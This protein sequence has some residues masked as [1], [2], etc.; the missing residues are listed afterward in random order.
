MKALVQRV[1]G[2][3]EISVNGKDFGGFRGPGLVA[4]LCWERGDEL[5][6][7]LAQ[8]EAWIQSRILGLRV[9]PDPQGRLNLGLLD[10]PT[11]EQRGI[12]WVSQFSLVAQLES[13]FRPSFAQAME[14]NAARLRWE[15]F[16]ECVK[17]ENPP[18]IVCLT[19]EFGADMS[20][21]FTNWGP[22]TIPLQK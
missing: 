6:A 16:S 20:L 18:G 5:R 14:P 13:G 11:Q 9:F 19:G 17:K 15:S 3:C 4:L 12:L 8:A 21:Q 22:L 7:D 10:Y 1:R 2:L